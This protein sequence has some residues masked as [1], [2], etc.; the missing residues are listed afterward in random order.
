LT[1]EGLP[2]DANA[3]DETLEISIIDT[4]VKAAPSASVRNE[5]IG[6]YVLEQ[7][8]DLIMPKKKAN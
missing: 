7:Y 5:N 3:V 4:T 1:G 2:K 8:K 6:A